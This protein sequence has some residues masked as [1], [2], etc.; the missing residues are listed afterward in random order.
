M[1][2]I[3]NNFSSGRFLLLFAL[4]PCSLKPVIAQEYFQQ[5]VN[6]TIDVTLNDRKHELSAFEEIGYINRSDDTL[7][8][9]YFHLWPNAYSNN[10]TELAKQLLN[11][12]GKEKLFKDP[13][14]KGFIDS[15]DFKVNENPV[16]WH[17]LKANPDICMILLNNPLLPGETIK[18]ST[19]FHV[20]LPKAVT[21]RLGHDGESYQVSQWYPKPAVYD[22]EGWHQMPY[23]DQGEFYSEFGTF[24]VNITLPDNYIVGA[25]GELQNEIELERLDKLAAD[26]L[27]IKDKY[28]EKPAFPPSSK[29]LKTLKFT[30]KHIHDFAW[31][32]DKRFHVRKGIVKLPESGRK[33]TTWVLFTDKQAKIWINADI[34]VNRA[35]V[36]LSNWIG[37][38]PYNSFTA[39][40]SDI[41]AGDG[42]EYPGLT[43]IGL[44]KDTYSLDEVLT[45]EIAHSWFYG[46][47]G[48]DER[49]YPFLD[50]GL[51]S[52]YEYRYMSIH[53]PGKKLWDVYIRNWKL[54]KFFHLNNMPVQLMQELE[55]LIQA[56]DNL[57]QPL[58]LA[59]PEYSK[60]NYD[61]LIYYKAGHGFNYLRAY[62]GDT[63][64][65]SI[66]HN[67]YNEWKFRHPQPIDLENAFKPQ[68]AKNLDWFFI[69]FL[70]TTKHIDYKIIRFNKQELLVRNKGEIAAPLIISGNTADSGSFEKWMDGFKG[71]KWLTIPAGNYRQLSIDKGHQMPELYRLN[72]NYHASGIFRKSDP[73]R[74]QFYFTLDDPEK[75]SLMYIPVVNW[76]RENGYMLGIAFHNGFLIPKPL[77]YIL[78]PFYSLKKPGIA[79]Y[80]KVSFNYLPY[81]KWI[82]KA[83]ISLEGTQF[84]APGDQDFHKIKASVNLFLR[85]SKTYNSFAQSISGNYILASNLYQIEI[86][87]KAQ[88]ASF[89]QM[90]YLVEKPGM[91]DPFSLQFTLEMSN[92][93][94]KTSM[95]FKYRYSYIGK[96]N[97]LDIRLFAGTMLNNSSGITYYS[98]AAG[99]RSGNEQYLLDGT[100]PDRFTSNHTTFLSRQVMFTEGGLISVVNDSLGYSNRLISVSL[101]SSLPGKAGIIPVKPFVNILLNDHALNQDFG[102]LFFF[103]AGI[104]TG[105]WNVLEIFV[106]LIVSRNIN[107]ISSTVKERIRITLNLDL[108]KQVKLDGGLLN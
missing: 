107:S 63:V 108:S 72:N 10:K 85:T 42:M 75:R 26:T 78:M 93:Y 25:S 71:K 89:F 95:E 18:I 38:Y 46:A 79:G 80:G 60:A 88:M 70:G 22:R 68:T 61:I 57:E 92:S 17:L 84:G 99:G 67:F 47:L 59:A 64:F 3:L 90:G 21:S 7:T 5:L 73:V 15:L 34:Y 35:I 40:E 28:P 20:K 9:L 44:A 43:V 86:P 62:L 103:E 51:A 27:W 76:T 31:F 77:D 81:G 39:I 16:K 36:E 94:Q 14:L 91:I 29:Q 58:N 13:Q 33:V 106:P 30:G 24:E 66:I 97:G 101:V 37:D 65:D 96:N 45:H 100:F 32:A 82:R 4:F 12:K 11:Q 55:W 41:N 98:L 48:F 50:E 8:F 105:I 74:K 6:Y 53:Y 19:P 83:K 52:A 49:R 56:R 2:K 54:A 102:S 87:L 69:D 23:L 104:K 1:R